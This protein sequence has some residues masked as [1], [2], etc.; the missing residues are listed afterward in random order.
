MKQETNNMTDYVWKHLPYAIYLDTNALRSAG[1]NLDASWINELLSIT[2]EYGIS[3]CISELVL[4]EWCEHIN[5]VLKGNRQKLLSSMALLRHYGISLPDIKPGEISL[6]AKLQLFGIVSGM[7][8]AAGFSVIPNWNAPLS[9]LLNEAV[10]KRPPFEQGGKGLC[11]AVIL[12]SYAEHAKE[13]FAKA[14]VLVISNDGAMKR[15]A[16]R[17]M[18]RK[19][20]VDFV[21]E[22]EIVAKLKSLLSDELSAYIEAK[23][24]KLTAYVQANEPEILDFIR[25]TPLEITD[26]MINPP[27]AELHDRIVGT[28]ESIL[29]VRPVRITDVIGGA[30][31]YGEET[32]KDR[33]P[34]RISVEIELEI[35][36]TEPG[37]WLG[38][39][40]P[41]ARAIVQPDILDSA[42]PVSLEK[43]TY[44]W[45]PRSIVKTIKRLLTVLATLDA[46]KEKNDVFDDLRIEKVF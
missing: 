46:Q 17:F 34:M 38:L 41:Q 37:S 15:S 35:V 28:I 12:E 3:V 4:S 1:P 20:V 9:R 14:R 5:G 13:N 19:I 18:D 8:K 42:S 26:W 16:E 44:D 39:L 2:N 23:K 11:D 30:P 40:G 25:K 31:T 45:K 6:P 27:S 32:A 24:S 7:M 43:K 21:G 33:Y 22:S 10:A 36:V 29:S